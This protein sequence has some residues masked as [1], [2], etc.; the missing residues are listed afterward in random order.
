LGQSRLDVVHGFLYI[1]T[2]RGRDL[3]WVEIGCTEVAPTYLM[4]KLS[5]RLAEFLC[6]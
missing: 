3:V 5:D 1:R 6:Q 2:R 4:R